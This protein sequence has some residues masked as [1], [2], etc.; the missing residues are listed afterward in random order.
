[1]AGAGFGRTVGTRLALVVLALFAPAWSARAQEVERTWETGLALRLG[2]AFDSRGPIGQVEGR[3][4]FLLAVERTV[5]LA[6]VGGL[7]VDW[8]PH[9]VPAVLVTDNPDA[10]LVRIPEGLGGW[11][12]RTDGRTVWGVGATPA[13]LR[14][15]WRPG[16]RLALGAGGAAGGVWFSS[17]VPFSNATHWNFAVDGSLSARFRAAPGRWIELGFRIY[18]L[19]NAGFGPENPGL[20]GRMFTVGV[21]W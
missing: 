19:S 6:T 18:H 15:E 7:D 14:L 17:P 3:E 16:E 13:A 11:V 10:P 9:L 12:A 2:A 4:I 5:H 20:D 21:G 1:M 8:T